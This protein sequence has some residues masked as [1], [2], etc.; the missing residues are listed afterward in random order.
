MMPMNVYLIIFCLLSLGI[1]TTQ[2]CM[3]QKIPKIYQNL[4]WKKAIH[5]LRK[6]N[7]LTN[8]EYNVEL[9]RILDYAADQYEQRKKLTLLP[10]KR[11]KLKVRLLRNTLK[12]K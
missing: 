3:E 11:S 6:D 8:E 10:E 2:Y 7:S 1:S 5:D 4:D 12:G 9:N